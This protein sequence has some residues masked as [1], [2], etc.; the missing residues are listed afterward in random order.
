MIRTIRNVSQKV[1]DKIKTHF[2]CSTTFS[3]IRVFVKKSGENILQ[4]DRLQMT[5]KCDAENMR[6]AC[7]ITKA[8]IQTHSHII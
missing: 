7:R 2:P 3:V 4:L 5:T 6:I 1:E 8:R